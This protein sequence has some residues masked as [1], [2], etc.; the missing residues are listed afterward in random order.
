ML[1]ELGTLFNEPMVAP[2]SDR[3]FTTRVLNAW[4]RAARGRF[5]TWAEMQR[6]ELGEDWRW[7]FVVDLKKS[8]G[9]P[10][11]IYIGDHL[12]KLSDVYLADA[13]DWTLSLLDV[14]TGEIEAAAEAQGPHLRDDELM[15]CDG[16]KIL[17]RSILAPLADD[18]E[19]ITHILGAATGRFA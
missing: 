8:V 12:S 7:V 18:G 17:F 19:N 3:R 14:A 16:R 15:L 6:V 1:S 11:F 9:F 2:P 10:F 13:T 4:A 5:P